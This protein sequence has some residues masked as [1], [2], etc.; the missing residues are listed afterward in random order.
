MKP[1][2]RVELLE[3]QFEV[4]K[5]IILSETRQEDLVLEHFSKS[6]EFCY[7][8]PAMSSSNKNENKINSP[9]GKENAK[10][11]PARNLLTSKEKADKTRI[12]DNFKS[13][14]NL[15]PVTK[16]PDKSPSVSKKKPIDSFI[17]KL[18]EYQET[19]IPSE[20]NFLSGQKVLQWE[21]ESLNLPP[22]ELKRFNGDPEQWPEFTDNFYSR[23]HRMASLGDNLRMDRLLSV[24]DGEA[25]RSILDQVVFFTPLLSKL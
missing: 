22:I 16:N 19:F 8:D 14:K 5:T 20:V 11:D 9:N 12:E 21:F 10:K 7:D 13:V 15:S 2:K 3:K 23:V 6:P 18:V 24:L 4:A 17:D 1:E 25:K